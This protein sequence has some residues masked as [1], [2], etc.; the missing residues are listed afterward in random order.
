MAGPERKQIR[1][2]ERIALAV[3]LLLRT[4]LLFAA[5]YAP[6]KGRW[7]DLFIIFLTL[8][9]TFLP[10]ILKKSVRLV[11][12][13]ELELVFVAFVFAAIFLG[14]VQRFYRL[15]WWWDVF[16]HALSGLNLGFA[17]FAILY[18]V[19]QQDRVAASPLLS[20]VFSF[21]FALALGALWEI[22]EFAMD[23]LFGLN[24]QKS[25]LVDTMGDLIVDAAAALLASLSGYFYLKDNRGAFLKR[26]LESLIEENPPKPG[27]PEPGG[28][29][30]G[31]SPP[32]GK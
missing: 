4:A 3:S 15:L 16:V 13:T 18:V 14:E 17:G 27:V 5:A 24:M 7:S 31:G 8:F 26:M 21:S 25:G 22:Y 19:I 20:A 29:G 12:P 30:Q 1:R 11:L 9:L 6:F 23:S 2:S 28:G 10:S 32:P